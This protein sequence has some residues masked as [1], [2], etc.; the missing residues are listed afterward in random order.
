MREEE[1]KQ[2]KEGERARQGGQAQA[3]KGGV[4]SHPGETT[5]VGWDGAAAVPRGGVI[6]SQQPEGMGAERQAW[7]WQG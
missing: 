4:G 6:S 2:R 7:M 5:G 3:V 1:R